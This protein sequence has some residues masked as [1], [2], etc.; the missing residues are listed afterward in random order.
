M[1][2]RAWTATVSSLEAV[3]WRT[4]GKTVNCPA[5][6]RQGGGLTL[7]AAAGPSGTLHGDAIWR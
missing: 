1:M 7:G 2:L 6:K 4:R 3:P 5:V